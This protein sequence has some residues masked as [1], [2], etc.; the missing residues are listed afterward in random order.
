M[1]NTQ[2]ILFGSLKTEWPDGDDFPVGVNLD[3]PSPLPDILKRFG[4]PGEKVQLVMINHKAVSKETVVHPGD[5]LTLFPREYP[6]FAD[7]HDLRL[8]RD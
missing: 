8:N 6:I 2:L 3:K 7:W 4:I 5:R 1:S